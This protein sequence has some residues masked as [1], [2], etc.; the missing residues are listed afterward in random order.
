M[1]QANPH[2]RKGD[3]FEEQIYSALSSS[4][5][6]LRSA[7]TSA[8]AFFRSSTSL[9][10]EPPSSTEAVALVSPWP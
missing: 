7:I 9:A 8:A 10:T 6:P 2:V 4:E 3:R 1:V 5:A